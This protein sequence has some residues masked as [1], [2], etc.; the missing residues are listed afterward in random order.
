MKAVTHD[1]DFFRQRAKDLDHPAMAEAK[2]HQ[3]C[4]TKPAG[5]LGQLEQLALNFAA[6]QGR[7][8]PQVKTISVVV[9]A[10]DHGVCAQG[11]SAF[12][13]EV[14]TQMVANFLAGGAAISVLSKQLH[15]D[16]NVVNAGVAHPLAEHEK[17]VNTPVAL[18]T[19]DF[20]KEAAMSPT[21]LFKA[22]RLGSE[23][24][25]HG[26]SDIF[27]GGEMGIGNTTSA[28]ALYSALLSLSPEE[29][30]GLGTG[31][32]MAGLARKRAIIGQAL[33]LHSTRLCD[34]F[35][36]L[37]CLGGY[38]ITALVGAYIRCAQRGIPVLVDGFIC[39]AAALVA[40]KINPSIRPWLLFAHQSAEPA[41]TRA[42]NYFKASPLLNLGMRLGEGSGAALALPL[43]QAALE[44]HNKMA[45]FAQA[46]VAASKG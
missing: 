12:A 24:V 9:F 39:T 20:S 1:K 4:L 42:L 17:L 34:P 35:E 2:K 14:T 28:S 43:I 26:H 46:G 40:E 32:D 31:V 27:I 10:G 33:A 18:G 38:E 5:S 15:A 7:A 19:A 30:V 16:F 45:T 44:L 23:Q 3:D 37:R 11:V 8:Y 13:Q 29:S 41:H 25:E 21:T 6:W 36:T 22:L